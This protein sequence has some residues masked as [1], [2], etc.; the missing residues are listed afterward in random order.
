MGLRYPSGIP[1]LQLEEDPVESLYIPEM[2]I[3]P[4]L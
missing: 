3:S 4:C 2:H 1:V